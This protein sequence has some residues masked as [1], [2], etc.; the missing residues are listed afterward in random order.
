MNK[1]TIFKQSVWDYSK[2][3]HKTNKRL[4]IIAPTTKVYTTKQITQTNSRLNKVDCT[5]IQ[6][7]FSARTYYVQGE[8]VVHPL[9]DDIIDG[10][11]KLTIGSSRFGLSKSNILFF[12]SSGNKVYLSDIQEFVDCE[13]RQ[14]RNYLKALKLCVLFIERLKVSGLIKPLQNPIYTVTENCVFDNNNEY[15]LDK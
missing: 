15:Y 10:V 13:V 14:A 5:H 9:I 8:L 7:F 3:L 6:C 12:L 4:K 1:Q 2:G 11:S